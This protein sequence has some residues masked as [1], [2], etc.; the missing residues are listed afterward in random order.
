MQLE[1]ATRQ[2]AVKVTARKAGPHD[3]KF[4]GVAVRLTLEFPPFV[5][6]TLDLSMTALVTGGAHLKESPTL[7]ELLVPPAPENLIVTGF[8]VHSDFGPELTE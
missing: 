1:A 2:C 8:V 3:A 5:V 7:P 4:D 6:L